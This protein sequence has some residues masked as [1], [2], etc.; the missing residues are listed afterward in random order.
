MFPAFVIAVVQ[1]ADNIF[2]T[3]EQPRLVRKIRLNAN[4]PVAPARTYRG[5]NGAGDR[6]NFDMGFRLAQDIP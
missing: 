4:H 2:V 1:T 3:F 5:G 6:G